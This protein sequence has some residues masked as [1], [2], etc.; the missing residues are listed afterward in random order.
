MAHRQSSR[1]GLPGGDLQQ[2]VEQ[3]Q[4]ANDKILWIEQELQH[5][6]EELKTAKE[7]LQATTE[8]LQ[9]I[10]AELHYRHAQL[11]RVNHDLTVGVASAGRENRT[12]DD[13][14][15]NLSHELRNPLTAI[16]GW[17]QLLQTNKLPA[18]TVTHGLEVIYRSAK[19]Q[20]Q[21]IDDMLDLS[22]IASGKQL[23]SSAVPSDLAAATGRS[24]VT[25]EVSLLEGLH[26]LAVD[27]EPHILDLL[28]YIL[29]DAGAVVTTVTSTR[30]ALSSLVTSGVKYDA[31]LSDIGMP[32]EDGLA[33]IGQVRA[34]DTQAGGQIPAAAIT[35]YGSERERQQAI[36]AGFQVH[37][38]K[39]FDA[40]QLIQMVANLTGR[41]D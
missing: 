40:E 3:V 7:E 9:T 17:A 11:E 22:Q 13:F 27:D 34:L 4:A 1:E 35:A 33:L 41:L 8:E 5:K 39:P 29:E 30:D 20:S 37:L 31:L 2:K 15:S 6:H 26:I 25:Q 19:V 32:D 16:I 12:Q 38:A 28:K 18:T 24:S 21:S 23:P 36:A 14:L 10:D